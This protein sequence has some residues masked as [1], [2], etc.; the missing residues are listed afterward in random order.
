MLRMKTKFGYKIKK[1]FRGKIQRYIEIFYKNSTMIIY[2]K[3][4]ALIK[5]II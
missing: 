3:R 2:W 5:N 4:V 1:I